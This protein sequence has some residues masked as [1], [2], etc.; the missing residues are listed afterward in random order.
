MPPTITPRN[1]IRKAQSATLTHQH[2]LDFFVPE[3]SHFLQHGVDLTVASPAETIRNI[4]GGN[5]VS[6]KARQKGYRLS[7]SALTPL[8]LRLDYEL[9]EAPPT[10]SSTSRSA[11]RC[12]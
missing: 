4:I 11:H 10:M 3:I 2:R 7:T 6:S 8:M 1:T 9:P 5:I 12:G